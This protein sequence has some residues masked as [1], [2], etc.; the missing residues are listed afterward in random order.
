MQLKLKKYILNKTKNTFS[1]LKIS[2]RSVFS[3]LSPLIKWRLLMP[4]WHF[5]LNNVLTFSFFITFSIIGT[6]CTNYL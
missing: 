3:V 4:F 6:V 2:G 5:T 1:V